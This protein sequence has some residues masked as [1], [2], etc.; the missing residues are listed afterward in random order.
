MHCAQLRYNFL[1]ETLSMNLDDYVSFKVIII[2]FA[3][4]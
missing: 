2:L 1:R 3:R 4:Y